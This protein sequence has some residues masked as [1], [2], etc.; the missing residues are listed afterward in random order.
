MAGQ[1]PRAVRTSR[2]LAASACLSRRAALLLAL[3]L[4]GCHC[5]PGAPRAGAA[6]RAAGGAGAHPSGAATPRGPAAPPEGPGAPPLGHAEL[7]VLTPTV[8]EATLVGTQGPGAGDRPTPWDWVDEE[9]GA[10]NDR[11]PLASDL[12]VTVDGEPVPV[13]AVGFRRIALLAPL[14]SRARREG[15]DLRIGN[16]LF[17]TLARRVPAGARVELTGPAGRF[18]AGAEAE[19][20]S[21]AL[22]VSQAGYEPSWPKRAQIGYHCGTLGELP[23][24][25]TT[26]EIVRRAD[27]YPVFA[28]PLVRRRDLGSKV[29]PA[30]YQE[31]FEADFSALTQPGDYRLRVPGMGSSYPFSIGDGASG[32]LARAL[33]LGVFHQRDGASSQALPWTRSVDGP[34]HLRPA[35]I[36]DGEPEFDRAWALLAATSAPSKGQRAAALKSPASALYPPLKRGAVDVSGGHRD[37][38]DYSKYTINSAATVAVLTFAVDSLAG[39]GRLDN[40]GIPESGDGVGDVLQEAKI[41][42]DFLARMQDDDGGFWFLVYP[43]ARRYED[44]V[45]PSGG[46]PQVVFPKSTSATAAA[47]GALAQAASSPAMRAAFPEAAALYRRRAE[48]GWAF[49]E[50]A[51]AAHG[52]EGAY[53]K[54]T[55]Y[56]DVF[57]HDDELAF[58]AAG[59]FAM[60]GDRAFEQRLMAAVPDPS[61]TSVRRWSWWRLFEGYGHAFRL[62][63]FLVRSGRLQASQL[64]AGYLAKVSAAV[65]EGGDAAVQSSRESAY[66]TSYDAAFKRPLN[67]GYHFSPSIAFDLAAAAE[68]EADPA[69]RAAL[70]DAAV[71]NV[72]YTTG[73]NPMNI[74][75]VTGVGAR[76]VQVVVSQFAQN[77]PARLPPTGLPVGEIRAGSLG[78]GPYRSTD[79]KNLLARLMFPPGNTGTPIYD[80]FTDSYD[81]GNEATIVDQARAAATA[82][83]LFARTD[84]GTQP[85]RAPAAAIVDVPGSPGAARLV[86][87]GLDLGGARVVWEVAGRAP[88]FGTTTLPD[89]GGGWI[90]AEADFPDGRRVFARR[91]GSFWK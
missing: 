87:P 27:G 26:F 64:D 54:I 17:V 20:Y 63:A 21:P 81:V 24:E 83:W 23:I 31:V 13:A 82:L 39:V 74:S 71:A 61:A 6:A 9:R 88:V 36:M 55:H 69:R 10:L 77:A 58:A 78:F 49:L 4:S 40:L 66:G 50:R 25:A 15:R 43:K 16:A 67:G 72:G 85:W 30:P 60:T 80:R 56:G 28:G 48:A 62:H 29:T 70:R 52:R 8:L 18:S 73:S 57:G 45:L 32:A 53:Q 75:F 46:D 38:G 5:V 33:S 12:A 79:G 44:D 7:R 35:Q 68:L 47:V 3:A 42:A 2:G 59:M 41:E 91:D 89:A 14:P 65:A 1:T 84:R 11:F 86:A 51:I 34:A 22:H 19:R 37:A 76:R 90:E